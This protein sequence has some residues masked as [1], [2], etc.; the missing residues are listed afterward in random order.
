ML[1]K[2]LRSVATKI[3]DGMTFNKEKLARNCL[4]VC[5]LNDRLTAALAREQEK[6]AALAA[7]VESLKDSARPSTFAPDDLSPEF[8]DLFSGLGKNP[9]KFPF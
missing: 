7:E 4:A 2:E 3:L 5:D 8:K 9:S 6:S 1:T